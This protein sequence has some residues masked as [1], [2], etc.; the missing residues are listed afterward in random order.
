ML[1]EPQLA[2][3]STQHSIYKAQAPG[4]HITAS[5]QPSPLLLSR[6][7]LSIS[8]TVLAVSFLR[9]GAWP[10]AP[11]ILPP[12]LPPLS[13]TSFQIS[14]KCHFSEAFPSCLNHNSRLCLSLD[15]HA[16]THTHFLSL[17][18]LYFFPSASFANTFRI[19]IFLLLLP[20]VCLPV[21]LGYK[22]HGTDTFSVCSRDSPHTQ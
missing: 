20:S 6:S 7:C 21:P 15:K 18:W 8:G 17:L 5:L 16:C 12:G 2:H 9:M 1:M 10:A 22:C 3:S 4:G 19:H 14:P 13:F 11:G